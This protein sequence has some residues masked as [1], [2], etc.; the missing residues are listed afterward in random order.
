[1]NFTTNTSLPHRERC[2][3]KMKKVIWG[4]GYY[5]SIFSLKIGRENVSFYIDKDRN[6]EGTFLGK[7]VVPPDRITDWDDMCV[8]V[9]Y[10]YYEEISTF[11]KTKKLA[12]NINFFKY[13]EKVYLAKDYAERDFERACREVDKLDSEDCKTS[14]AWCGR[15]WATKSEYR[16]CIN[17]LKN[18]GNKF[19]LLADTPWYRKNEI[20]NATNC[21]TVVLPVVMHDFVFIED[22]CVDGLIPDEKETDASIMCLYEN[23]MARQKNVSPH[24]CKYKAVMCANFLEYLF[25]KCR[26]RFF[27]VGD[28]DR[29]ISKMIRDKCRKYNVSIL[30]THQGV[31]PGTIMMGPGGDIGDSI[32]CVYY[33]EFRRLPLDD[34][35]LLEAK[36][37]WNY[38]KESRL[39]R[40]VQPC[41]DAVKVV[42]KKISG[43]KPTIVCLG[44]ND[45]DSSMI[46]YTDES[47]KYQSPI[48]ESSMS[49]LLYLSEVCEK[50][51]WNLVYKPHP[52]FAE[53]EDY[54]SLPDT[55]V[56]VKFGDINEIVDLA[57]VVVT[58]RSSS[59]YIA[60]I[61]HKPVLMMGYTQTRGQ[62]CTYEAFNKD[63][64]EVQLRLALKYGFSE[65]QKQA[66]L[67]HLARLLKYYLYDDLSKRQIRYGRPYPNTI[68][69]FFDL[70]NTLE[71]MK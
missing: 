36:K 69:G 24:S 17:V 32:P 49:S 58:I 59:N 21:C 68:D 65:A 33:K 35:V 5:A 20:E 41:N 26:F 9:P 44:Q 22:D 71:F 67:E 63:D 55:I 29:A 54:T 34:E 25:K 66:F 45:L 1:M 60:L 13:D 15:F 4:T 48:F 56:L 12:E 16:E 19:I 52:M 51:N 8:Y 50:N 43:D 37:V 27:I 39:N 18:N 14:T 62:G 2:L 47:I 10:N 40:K 28:S 70:K 3:L 30:F 46:P 6:K 7:S 23:I 64:I 57:D 53:F 61:R 42:N 11:L 38:L 31:V